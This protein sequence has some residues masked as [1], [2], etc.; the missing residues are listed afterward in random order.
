ML[1]NSIEFIFAFLPV[2]LIVYFTLTHFQYDREA[3]IWLFVASLFF[4]GWWN[5]KYLM[6]IGSSLVVNF[7]VARFITGAAVQKTKKWLLV[8]GLIFN[9]GL[10][11]YYKYADFFILNFNYVLGSDYNLFNIIL[12]L[13][14]S[15]Y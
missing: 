12:P 14:I 9:I 2:T 3:K 15:F 8:F 11:G 5:P 6:L 1:F 4:Y 7:L 13:G 10:L